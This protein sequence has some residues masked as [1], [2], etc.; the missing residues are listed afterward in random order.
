MAEVRTSK[1]HGSAEAML[2]Q[3][4]V[5]AHQDRAVMGFTA[6]HCWLFEDIGSGLLDYKKH[7]GSIVERSGDR[8]RVTATAAIGPPYQLS[9][10]LRQAPAMR[11]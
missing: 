4:H 8:R 10:L 9:P 6:R 1:V 11:C 3:L 5:L 2:S 7:N